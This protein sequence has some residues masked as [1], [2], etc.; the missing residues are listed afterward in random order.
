M[1]GQR[2]TL[3][4][5]FP[6][7]VAGGLGLVMVVDFA[8]MSLAVHSFPGLAT[9]NGFDHSNSYDRVLAAAERERALGWTVGQALDGAR[10]IVTLADRTGAPL[11]G[12][13][14]VVAVERPLG[15]APPA[16][17]AFHATAPGRFEADAA[18]APGQWNLDLIVTTPGGEYHTTRRLVVH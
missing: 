4:R 3:W 13:R 15:E 16:P 6:W 17:L 7:F 12:A 18:L 5:F 9:T 11:E 8:G 14:L 2:R 1:S 10:P